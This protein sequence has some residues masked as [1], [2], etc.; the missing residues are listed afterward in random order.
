MSNRQFHHNF[1]VWIAITGRRWDRL[2]RCPNAS[3]VS[4][5][6]PAMVVKNYR[7][8]VDTLASF[9]EIDQVRE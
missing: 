6:D 1:F 7:D 9:A 8:D 2:S 5:A 3:E 4:S